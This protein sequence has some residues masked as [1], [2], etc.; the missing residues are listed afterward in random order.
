[1]RPR[2]ALAA[3]PA[4]ARRLL[5]PLRQ[6]LSHPSPRS[7][8]RAPARPPRRRLRPRRMDATQASRP[9]L[10]PKGLHREAMRYCPWLQ[11]VGTQGCHTHAA[12]HTHRLHSLPNRPLP[13]RPT[14]RARRACIAKRCATAHGFSQWAHRAAHTHRSL[15][16]R[17]LNALSPKGLH[18]K[19]MHY[20]PW[21][22]PVGTK[23]RR[24]L[25][26]ELSLAPPTS[27]GYAC[28]HEGLVQARAR[29]G[30]IQR[31]R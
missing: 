4:L 31:A 30:R 9:S 25:G 20:C 28:A 14:R 18:R 21:L 1:M 13:D 15:R 27:H 5:G 19:A 11:P 2:R 8:H 12:A 24:N 23:G 26:R 6:P 10:S 7:L 16:A 3:R 22:Q 29:H 17:S